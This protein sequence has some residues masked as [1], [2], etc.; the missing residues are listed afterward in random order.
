VLV[1]IKPNTKG[2]RPMTVMMGMRMSVDPDRFMELVASKGEEM[3]AISAKGREKGAAHHMFLAGDGEVMIADEWDSAE[4]FLAFF[5]EMGA[6]IGALMAEAGVSNAPQ[7][8]FWRPL[9]TPDRF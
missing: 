2:A 1:V 8:T 4:S 7:P 6:E 9:D 5:E 3:K